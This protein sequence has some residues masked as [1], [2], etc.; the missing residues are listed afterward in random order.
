MCQEDPVKMRFQSTQKILKEIE[1]DS[2]LLNDEFQGEKKKE[3]IYRNSKKH[4]C[5]VLDVPHRDMS[6][7]EIKMLGLSIEEGVNEAV[8]KSK[9]QGKNFG[10]MIPNNQNFKAQYQRYIFDFF[11]EANEDEG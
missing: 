7:H 9:E 4:G 8:N 10:D 5:Y 2:R 6:L 11:K 3:L 1:A